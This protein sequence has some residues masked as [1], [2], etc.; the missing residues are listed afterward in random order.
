MIMTCLAAKYRD[1]KKK[2]QRLNL[3]FRIPLNSS[4]FFCL[5]YKVV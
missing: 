3:K 4:W 5:E 1:I 2:C